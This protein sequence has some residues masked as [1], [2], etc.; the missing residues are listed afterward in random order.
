MGIII[1][2]FIGCGR[3]FFKN[4][5]SNKVKIFDAVEELPLTNDKGKIDDDLLESYFN[6]VMSIVDSTDVVFIHINKSVRDFFSMNGVDYDLFYPSENRRGEFIENQ[7]RKRA[8]PKDIQLLDKNFAQW[9]EEIDNYDSQNCYKHKLENKYEY[10]GN[11]QL[12]NNY[13]NS[14][15]K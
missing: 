12:I 6:K 1:S 5:F 7:V 10:I 9:V 2:S 14:L 13:L 11:S 3:E 8:K 4:A 15:I